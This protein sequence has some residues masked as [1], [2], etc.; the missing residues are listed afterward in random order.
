MS[1]TPVSITI[2]SS[3][4]VA[5]ANPNQTCLFGTSSSGTVDT[6]VYIGS[7]QALTE[8]FGQGPLVDAAASYLT[9]AGPVYV[10]RVAEASAGTMGS[11]TKTAAGAGTGTVADNS[12]DPTNRFAVQIQIKQTGTIAAGTMRYRYSTDG[13]NNWSATLVGP[14]AGGGSASVSLGTTGIAV[15]LADGAG[16]TT[17]FISGDLFEFSTTPPTYDTSGLTD[18]VTA[19]IQAPDIN[20]RRIH[21]VG[22]DGATFHST[23]ISLVATARA[24][25]KYFRVLEESDNQGSGESVTTWQAGVLTDFTTQS[26]TTCVIAGWQPML[27]S[28]QQ[29]G[30]NQQ[31]TVPIAWS[32]GP[33]I[34]EIDLGQDPGRAPSIEG[35]LPQTIVDSSNPILQDG[36][37]YLGLQDM[38]IS[39]GQSYVG[40]QGLYSAGA[41]TRIANPTS[42][43]YWLARCQVIDLVCE[44]CYKAALAYVITDVSA[45]ADGTITEQAAVSIENDMNQ[46]VVAAVVSSSPQ[47]VSPSDSGEYVTVDRSNDIVTTGELIIT[48][49]LIPRGFIKTVSLTIGYKI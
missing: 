34:Q 25:Y 27:L 1:A 3:N 4:K 42:V 13:G 5:I 19:L 17:G 20:V 16:P 40:L 12:S 6:P 10:C 36:R 33:R 7:V 14:S 18:A 23:L 2:A 44:V 39:Y 46:A 41:F 15:T 45:N 30:I 37:L 29:D 9:I 22:T 49:S 31:R 48:V 47:R 32:V 43:W 8:T 35:P 26:D 38:G 21:A 11:V 24:G 28:V